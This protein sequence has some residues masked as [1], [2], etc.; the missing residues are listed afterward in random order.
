MDEER[1]LQRRITTV[2]T[3]VFAL[4]FDFATFTIRHFAVDISGLF[5]PDTRRLTMVVEMLGQRR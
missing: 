5:L 3:F 2:N 1:V 4:I